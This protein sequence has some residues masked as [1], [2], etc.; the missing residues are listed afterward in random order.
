MIVAAVASSV[1]IMTTTKCAQFRHPEFFLEANESQVP[2]VHLTRIV[3]TLEGMVAHGSVFKP[4]QT[5]Q[6]GWMLTLVQSHDASRLTLHEPDMQA[7]PMRWI[8]GITE[9]LRQMMVQLYTLDSFSLRQEINVPSVLQSLIACTQYTDPS[10]FMERGAPSAKNKADTGW[11]VG[12]LHKDHNHNDA[13]NLRCISVYEAFLQ[14]RGILNFMAFPLGSMIVM[15]Q[16]AALKAW[17]DGNQL[18]IVPGSFLD[19]TL[20]KHGAQM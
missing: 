4:G 12:C 5:Y 8:P 17:K 3:Q 13:A 10:F 14:Q 18:S 1:M 7:M 9:T 15:D 20:S 16:K 6:V 11:F 2:D 19:K